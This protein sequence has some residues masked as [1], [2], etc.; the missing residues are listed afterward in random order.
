MAPKHNN[1]AGEMQLIPTTSRKE[2]LY[3]GFYYDVTDWVKRH[4]GGKIIEFYTKSGEDCTIAVQQFHQR[5]TKKVMAIMSSLKK[6]P[7]VPTE[8]NPNLF[9]IKKI[10]ANLKF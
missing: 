9:H 4:P 3:E 1:N 6:R 5:S 10:V 8:S 2:I 7:A